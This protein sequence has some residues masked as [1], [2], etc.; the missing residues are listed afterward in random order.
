M[1]V[2]SYILVASVNVVYSK[3]LLVQFM[4]FNKVELLNSKM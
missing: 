1:C 2:K 4:L 3:S